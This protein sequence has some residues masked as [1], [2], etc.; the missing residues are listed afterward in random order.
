MGDPK[1]NNKDNNVVEISFVNF[2]PQEYKDKGQ[3][4]VGMNTDVLSDLIT[5]H[6]MKIGA[7][8]YNQYV[9]IFDIDVYP[10]ISIVQAKLLEKELK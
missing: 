5:D 8:T 3:V 1:D 7:L 9:S 4:K 2:H 6:N 10:D